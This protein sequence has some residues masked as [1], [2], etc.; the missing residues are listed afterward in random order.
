MCGKMCEKCGMCGKIKFFVKKVE[1][2]DFRKIRFCNQFVTF[3]AIFCQ[4][5]AFMCCMCCV[6]F[7][8]YAGRRKKVFIY[9]KVEKFFAHTAH[10]LFSPFFTK[11]YKRRKEVS[12]RILQTFITGNE[13]RKIRLKSIRS[14][15]QKRVKT[16]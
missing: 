5:T 3:Q 15:S 2:I 7:K 16:L 12:L 11:N 4:K 13:E 1:K 8:T 10:K 14:L 6:F 9:K